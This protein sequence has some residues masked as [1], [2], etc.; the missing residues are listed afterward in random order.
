MNMFGN[1]FEDDFCYCFGS[2][3]YMVVFGNDL[4]RIVFIVNVVL[5]VF[6]CIMVILINVLV[7]ILIWYLYLL[8]ILVN[9]LLISFVMFDLGVGLIF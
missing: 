8:W 7:I 5:N 3:S 2:F 1:I 4:F 6:F 9:M